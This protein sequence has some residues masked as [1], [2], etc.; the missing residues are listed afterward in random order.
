MSTEPTDQQDVLLSDKEWSAFYDEVDEFQDRLY[1]IVEAYIDGRAER[2]AIATTAVQEL[3]E[4]LALA[5][6]YDE[7][8]DYATTEESCY[9]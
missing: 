3:G 2:L 8:D 7:E 1:N 6:A 5:P 4:M 9:D